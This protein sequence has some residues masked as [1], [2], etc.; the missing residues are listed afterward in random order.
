MSIVNAPFKKHYLAA[1]QQ[2]ITEAIDALPDHASV[3]EVIGVLEIIKR[4]LIEGLQ[5]EE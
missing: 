1:L 5:K 2:A 3:A 4:D